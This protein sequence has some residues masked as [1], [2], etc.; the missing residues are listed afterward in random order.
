M[1]VP[2]RVLRR[3][4]LPVVLRV[5][6]LARL[7]YRLWGLRLSGGPRDQ[8]WYFAYGANMDESV[9]R[10]RCGI[11]PREWR[12]G[13]LAGFRLRFNLD[14][15]PL[16]R[17][18]PA[19]IEPAEN[20]EVWGVL[21][22]ISRRDMVRLNATEGVPGRRYTPVAVR[23]TD[24]EGNTHD[25]FTLIAGGNKEDGAPSRRYINLLRAGARAHGLPAHW[26][27][28]LDSVRPASDAAVSE[29]EERK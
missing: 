3:L 15:R 12:A 14:G 26:T 8:V 11:D 21:Y 2:R 13:R 9:L 4:W 29:G 23:T 25:A 19:N 27:A 17:A 6:P 5:W 18:A 7:W 16:G 20:E 24:R 1:I 10:E 28:K 22:R